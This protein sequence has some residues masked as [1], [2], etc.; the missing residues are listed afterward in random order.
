MAENKDHYDYVEHGTVDFKDLPPLDHETS[1]IM[2]D[3]LRTGVSLTV[4]YFILIFSIPVMNWY[5]PAFAF[6]PI[7]GGMTITWF[8]TSVVMMAMSFIIAYVHT[9]LYEKRLAKYDHD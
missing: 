8:V 1:E 5:F 4:F 3:E 9:K 6:K 2:H 7:W